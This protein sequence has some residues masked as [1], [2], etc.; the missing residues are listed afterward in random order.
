MKLDYNLARVNNPRFDSGLYR[1]S[2][3]W[4]QLSKIPS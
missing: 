3:W 4:L 1:Q 2:Q